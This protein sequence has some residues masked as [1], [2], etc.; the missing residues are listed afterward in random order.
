MSRVGL[1]SLRGF[2]GLDQVVKGVGT[3]SRL[4]DRGH[5]SNSHLRIP[6]VATTDLQRVG[7]T[8]RFQTP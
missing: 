3:E 1:I 7:E 2:A 6:Y 4:R 8:P 5:L